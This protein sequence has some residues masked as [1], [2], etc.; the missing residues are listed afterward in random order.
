MHLP[1]LPQD[2]LFFS[3]LTVRETLTMAA[4]LR[5]PKSVGPADRQRCVAE[6]ITRLGLG[7]SADTIVGDAKTRGLSGGEKK[8]CVILSHACPCYIPLVTTSVPVP[9]T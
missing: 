8:R 9:S 4:E 7:A 2:D 5:L 6:V 1:I 3:Q